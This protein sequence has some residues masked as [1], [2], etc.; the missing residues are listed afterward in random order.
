MIKKRLFTPGP[1]SVF[2]AA[3]SAALEANIHHRTPEFKEVLAEVMAALKRVLG[4]PAHAFLF[5]SSGSGAMEAAVTNFFSAGDPV[6]VASCGKFGERWI[7]LTERYA[8]NA[9]VLKYPYGE[10][11]R[12]E[13]I[14]AALKQNPSIRGVFLQAC[15]SS[16][17]VQNDVAAIAR[18][19]ANSEGILVV[20]AVTGL[21]TMPISCSMGVD[22]I[23]SGSQKALMIPP[24]LGLI[25]VSQ[26]A[27]GR[28][29]SAT[30]P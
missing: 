14:E 29:E 17:A 3:L 25:G 22:V 16:T 15:E 4:D 30:L 24:G 5:A 11:V 13:D 9:Q 1:V 26:K 28:V 10:A 8:L 27:W 6:V 20:D 18:V 23:V 12:P 7:E 21:G 19:V 2:P